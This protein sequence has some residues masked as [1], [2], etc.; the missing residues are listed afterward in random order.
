M[1]YSHNIEDEGGD[2]IKQA[3]PDG[4]TESDMAKAKAAGQSE[5]DY[6]MAKVAP[7]VQQFTPK[8]EPVDKV[9]KGII[10]K[11]V[12]DALAVSNAAEKAA[13]SDIL[14]MPGEQ[15]LAEVM[16]VEA[17]PN[18]SPSKRKVAKLVRDELTARKEF[19]HTKPSTPLGQ[20]RKPSGVAK[21][22]GK[23]VGRAVETYKGVGSALMGTAKKD[24]A[25]VKKAGGAVVDFFGDIKEAATN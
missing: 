24:I 20:A 2:A 14:D 18:A 17:D 9:A 23:D 10:S 4:M 12:A 22:I 19:T 11:N 7:L 13:V 5:M 3:F 8:A 6:M 15:A 1:I 25:R 21:A 16:K